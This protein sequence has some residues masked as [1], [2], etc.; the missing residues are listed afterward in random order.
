M[1]QQMGS[2][3]SGPKLA[4]IDD[5][6]T[7]TRSVRRR[8]DLSRPVERAVI[9]EC[10]ELAVHAPNAED[11]Q[12]WRWLILTDP[13]RRKVIAEF[14]HMAWLGHNRVGQGRRRGRFTN[15]QARTSTHDSARWLAE[16]LGR[17]PVL[18]LPCVVGRP[19][20]ED[21]VRRLEASWAAADAN[22]GFKPKARLVADATFYGSI[23]PAIWSFQLALRSR[24]L[25]STITTMHLPFHELVAERLGIPKHVTQ[26]ALLPVAYTVGNSFAPALRAAASQVTIWDAWLPRP[27]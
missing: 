25:G 9:E 21:T 14:Y 17:V 12:N 20:T 23:F 6:L 26:V 10:L 15:P 24:G 27:G 3:M 11:R 2:A 8:L 4:H 1:N 18:V 19:V 13:D 7:T 22:M 16:N 5:V